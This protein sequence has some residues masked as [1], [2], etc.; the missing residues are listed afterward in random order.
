V[1]RVPVA[2][3]RI[4]AVGV[5]LQAPSFIARDLYVYFTAQLDEARA[6]RLHYRIGELPEQTLEASAF[7]FEFTA[8]L[9]L[10]SAD[11]TWWAEIQ[12]ADGRW[13]KAE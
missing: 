8:R 11:P 6:A 4:E 10:G 7:P 13:Q 9:P 5:I 3:S 2:G 1:R 12:L